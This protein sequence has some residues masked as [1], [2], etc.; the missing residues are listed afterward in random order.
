VTEKVL[1][2][3]GVVELLGFSMEF[4]GINVM[5][6]RDLLLASSWDIKNLS[7]S[8]ETGDESLILFAPTDSTFD[9]YEETIQ[10]LVTPP[11]SRHLEDS[12]KNLI[13][14]GFTPED[15]VEKASAEGGPFVLQMLGGK[16]SLLGSGPD[17]LEFESGSVL[18]PKPVGID[19]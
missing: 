5:V 9:N 15:L 2:P 17:D 11:W 16:E 4:A 8:L 14:I 18:S 6:M 19:G 10:R 7:L 13:L 1:E 12:L 3:P